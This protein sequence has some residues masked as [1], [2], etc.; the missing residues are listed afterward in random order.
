MRLFFSGRHY[1]ICIGYFG[2]SKCI[3]DNCGVLRG[4]KEFAC[5]RKNLKE[6]K[7]LNSRLSS[8]VSI[9]QNE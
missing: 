2:L 3:S 6:K 7:G 5:F 4:K 1:F 9:F 8:S